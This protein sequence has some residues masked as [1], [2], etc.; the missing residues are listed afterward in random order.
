MCRIRDRRACARRRVAGLGH[1]LGV[2][3]A[4]EHG[5]V[6]LG[7]GQPPESFG[8]LWLPDA[9]QGFG[10][11][12]RK[13]ILTGIFFDGRPQFLMVYSSR[14]EIRDEIE[15]KAPNLPLVQVEIQTSGKRAPTS[16]LLTIVP[17]ARI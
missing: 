15:A 2:S 17:A 11:L 16:L 10:L 14:D 7:I 9:A 3:S 12:D 5:L 8:H 13:I 6:L 4:E 1:R